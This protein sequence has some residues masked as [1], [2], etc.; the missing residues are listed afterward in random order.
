MS[1]RV[2]YICERDQIAVQMLDKGATSREV[3]KA[4]NIS[5]ARVNQIAKRARVG[6]FN[7]TQPGSFQSN[8][9]RINDFSY[10]LSIAKNLLISDFLNLNRPST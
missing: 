6:L 4:L 7:F 2:L 9:V 8:G 5:N 1:K 10:F 3:G